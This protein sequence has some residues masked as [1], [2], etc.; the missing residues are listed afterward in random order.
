MKKVSKVPQVQDAEKITV[1][2]SCVSHCPRESPGK[3]RV[4]L[5]IDPLLCVFSFSL[6][7]Q[8]VI[9]CLLKSLISTV[10][11]KAF[12]KLPTA[13]APGKFSCHH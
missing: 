3:S 4:L 2:N 7:T 10:V 11:A 13:A 12:F 5:S 9:L 8:I 6:G 1:V